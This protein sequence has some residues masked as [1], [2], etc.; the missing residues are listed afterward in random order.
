[1]SGVCEVNVTSLKV[2]SYF[3]HSSPA[4]VELSLWSAQPSSIL[5]LP[6]CCPQLNKCVGRPFRTWTIKFPV[7]QCWQ[8]FYSSRGQTCSVGQEPSLFIRQPLSGLKRFVYGAELGQPHCNSCFLELPLHMVALL[9]L[10]SFLPTF[11]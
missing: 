2:G 7:L 3:C 1:M 4:P 8:L 6:V 11:S 9:P 5:T 10:G